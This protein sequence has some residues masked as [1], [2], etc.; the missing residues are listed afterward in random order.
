MFFVWGYFFLVVFLECQPKG[1]LPFG[2]LE[3]R[4]PKLCWHSIVLIGLIGILNM[5]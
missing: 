2:A 5:A 4:E 3:Q 1:L